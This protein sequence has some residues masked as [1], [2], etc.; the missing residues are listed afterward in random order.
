M[1][2]QA[3]LECITMRIMLCLCPNPEKPLHKFFGRF[4][5]PQPSGFGLRN[6]Q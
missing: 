3:G 6:F 5:A 2:E 4:N 1:A